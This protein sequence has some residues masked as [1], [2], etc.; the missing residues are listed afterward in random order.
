MTPGRTRAGFDVALEWVAYI[1]FYGYVL[2]LVVAG[3]WGALFAPVD[4]DL[5]LGF[6]LPAGD[7]LARANVLSQYRFLRAIEL[8]VG[9]II[10]V[11][12][13]EVFSTRRYN[14]L[15]L[16]VL[17]AGILGRVISLV[18]DGTPSPIFF[19]FIVSELAALVAI[20]AHTRRTGFAEH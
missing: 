3:A 13:R 11:Y 5:L 20:Y 4:F 2:L 9:V 7:D 17:G 14:R 6:D 16:M 12:R 18:V 15:F 8:S 19:F 1:L 10:L